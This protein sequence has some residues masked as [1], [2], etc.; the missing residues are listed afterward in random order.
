MGAGSQPKVDFSSLETVWGKTVCD[1]IVQALW[2]HRS[3]D[4]VTVF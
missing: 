4:L 1:K 3:E 2:T